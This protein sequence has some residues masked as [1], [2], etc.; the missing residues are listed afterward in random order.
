MSKNTR[1]QMNTQKP[2]KYPLAKTFSRL[3]A[4]GEKAFMPYVC[5][6]D[7]GENF[8]EKL[9]ETLCGNGADV[10]ELGIPFSD[11]VADGPTI[12]AASVRGLVG[13][14]TPKKALAL[15]A[16][17]RKKGI[18]AP[19]VV[20]TYYNIVFHAGA[21]KFA[22]HAARAGASAILCPD[23]PLE[24]S[25]ILRKACLNAG[26]DCVFLAAPNTPLARL[27][28]ILAKANGFLYL[29]S[30][31]GTTGARKSVS[32]EAIALVVRAKKL[33]KI[34]VAVGF[35]VSTPNQAR[36]IAN[37]GADGVIVG[38]KIVDLY[39]ED[40]KCGKTE[41]ALEKVAAFSREMKASLIVG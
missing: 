37:A 10:I 32:T 30:V 26:L 38:S 28:K 31:S 20:M 13:G 34:P 7:F 22:L 4:Q 36:E 3:R 2:N 5:C 41:N 8:T 11:P 12:Q 24:E 29:V 17:V 23:V 9:I 6:G 19:I 35:G 25:E 33:S 16:R 1:K 15:I 39:S 14:M 40:A 27:E 18:R 21:E